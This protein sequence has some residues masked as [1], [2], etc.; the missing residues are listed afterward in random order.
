MT[1]H[2]LAIAAAA[3]VA[4]A[5]LTDKACAS[6]TGLQTVQ[7][8]SAAAFVDSIG[9][10]VHF[11]N[12]G[13]VYVKQF[14]MVKEK[15]LALGITHLRDGA[16]DRG[17][18]FAENDGAA[19]FREL[20]VAGARLTFLFNPNM[21]KDFVQGFPERVA[22]AFEAYEFPNEFN[23]APVADWVGALRAW[24]P[25]Y[26]S[27]VK[28]NNA[29]ARYPVI[30]PSLADR[31]DNP[32]GAL[33]DLSAYLDFGN[34]HAYYTA[35][36]PA[37]AGW[38]GPG[39]SPCEAWRYGALDYNLC[40]ARRVSGSKAILS[41]E[42]GWGSDSKV[43]GQVTPALQAKYLVRMLLLHFNAGVARTFI[44]QLVDSGSDG[45]GPYGLVTATGEEKPAFTQIKNLIAL[46]H[47]GPAT[48]SPKTLPLTL[49]GDTPDV[50]TML[51]EKSDRT[52]R[53][54][55]WIEK[56]GFDPF[57]RVPVAV[58]PIPVTLRLDKKARVR[59]AFLFQDDGT[60]DKET[61]SPDVSGQYPLTLTDNLTVLEITR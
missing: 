53:L 47:D 45:F 52:F 8:S 9:V 21:S 24:A 48:G 12:P 57:T 59:A 34:T 29:T 37:T 3:A 17:G 43:L 22:P 58:P 10:N 39:A 28:S 18:G 1:A 7:A 46:L 44:Y 11:S 25:V 30:G 38:G 15:L 60:P 6:P 49:T 33:G 54:I 2:A 61:P 14:S 16:V 40:N 4:G 51:F 55:V 41:T 36:H 19:L 23:A 26:Y 32:A 13:S 42:T 27:Y 5:V 56:Q 35:R 31:G 50:R 20:G